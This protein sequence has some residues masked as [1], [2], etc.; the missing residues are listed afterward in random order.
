MEPGGPEGC[1]G[2]EAAFVTSSDQSGNATAAT[3]NADAVDSCCS[4]GA[5]E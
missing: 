5:C 1:I 4:H 2:L 3:C